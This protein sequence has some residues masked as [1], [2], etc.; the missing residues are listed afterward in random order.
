M[1][2]GKLKLSR[3]ATESVMWKFRTFHSKT[4]MLEPLFNKVADLMDFDVRDFDTIALLW[5]L[6]NFEEHLLWRT[7]AN[8][9]FENLL[10][11]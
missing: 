4:L 7:F 3:K 2:A 9:Y 6:Q 5:N 10:E 1:K 11:K 8:D